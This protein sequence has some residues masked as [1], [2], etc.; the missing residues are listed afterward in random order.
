MSVAIRL[1]RE[2]NHDRP[3]YRL[4]AA[5]SRYRRDGR[6][7]EV[8]GHYDPNVTSG[9]VTVNLERVDAWLANGAKPSETAHSLIKR[10]RKSTA[11]G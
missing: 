8:L 2:G 11:A 7:L 4:V 6:F 5:D 1:R 9:G 3:I 10:A